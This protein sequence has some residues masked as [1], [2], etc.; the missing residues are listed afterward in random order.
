MASIIKRIPL[1]V[2]CGASE[3][4]LGATLSQNDSPATFYS[5]TFTATDK[6]YFVI[7]KEAAAIMDAVKKWNHPGHRFTL[8]TDQRAVSFMLDPK[9]LGKIRN[10][11]LQLG[12]AE[13]G[14][15]YYHIE[16]RPGKQNFVAN[17]L[18]R[19]PSI[20]SCYFDLSKFH[21]QLG[22]PG[23][24]RL[25]HFER[26]KNLSFSTKDVKKS[27]KHIKSVP[28]LNPKFF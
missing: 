12:R 8:V 26:S 14:N 28:N 11:K 3:H 7:E 1:T 24:S 2:E 5:R 15:F 4:S 19:V 10:T 6:S 21:Q 25:S 13:L 17:A 20:A 16:Y 9:Q 18:S 22:N 23:V 27:I